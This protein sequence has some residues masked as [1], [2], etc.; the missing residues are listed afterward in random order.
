MLKSAGCGSF[1]E[2][3]TALRPLAVSTTP[4]TPFPCS[5]KINAV[6]AGENI[7]RDRLTTEPNELV[8]AGE[9]VHA[10]IR[11][12]SAESDQHCAS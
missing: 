2:M 3:K 9:V 6:D 10:Y 5:V 4:S 11:Q 8:R 12:R 1:L 7:D